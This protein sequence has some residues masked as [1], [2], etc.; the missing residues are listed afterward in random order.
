MAKLPPSAARAISKWTLNFE[1]DDLIAAYHG[2]LGALKHS[3]AEVEPLLRQQLG[4]GPH[5]DLPDVDPDDPNDPLSLIFV[6]AVERRAQARRGSLIIRKTFLI[7]LFHLWERSGK[8]RPSQKLGD[9]VKT[10]RLLVE[11][12]QVANCAKHSRGRSAKAAFK[13]RPDLFP[14]AENETRANERTL[15]ISEATFLEFVSAV[16]ATAK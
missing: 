1:L 15:V 16:R 8:V 3:E 12:E 2:A 7:A 9:R 11:L 14:G 10:N 13:S 6:Q 4:L 5:D